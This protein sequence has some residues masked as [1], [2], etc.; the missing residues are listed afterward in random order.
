MRLTNFPMLLTLG[1]YLSP[2]PGVL[3]GLLVMLLTAQAPALIMV[4]RGNDPVSDHNWPAGS[5][6][7]ANLKS[8]VGWWEGPPF[9]GGQWCFLYRGD[10]K[11]A[12]AA[13]DLFAKIRA[14]RLDVFVHGDGPVENGFL[15][16]EKDPK[17]DTHV[18]WSFTVWNPESWNHLHN[19]ANSRF[20][21]EDPN[22]GYHQGVEP[23]RIDLYVGGKGID[24]ASIKMPAGVT[25]TDERA[26][27]AGIDGGS[28]IIADFYDMSTSKPIDGAQIRLENSGPKKEGAAAVTGK[29]DAKGHLLLKGVPAGSYQVL[30]SAEGYVARV[31]GYAEFRG[32]TLKR[33][34]VELAAPG[35]IEGTVTDTRGKRI[36]GVNVR[37]DAVVASNGRGYLLPES[38]LAVTDD[39][40]HFVISGLPHGSV[41]LFT[42]G[43]SYAPLDVLAVHAVPGRDVALHMTAT[44][45]LKGK[46]YTKAAEPFK[47]SVMA[48]P[49][50]DPIGKWG[51]GM[52][53]KPDGSY[54]FENV[55][56][57]DYVLTTDGRPMPGILVTVKAGET[58]EKDLV[59]RE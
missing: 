56:P 19:G 44:G 3:A 10:A 38:K 41:Q 37:A 57:G 24:L 31:L 20:S 52:N 21:A 45:T 5:L 49:P 58:T 40:G 53:V 25:V 8:R 59:G 47:G 36:A 46:V 2:P 42:Y 43:K 23:P 12:Q 54:L 51:G 29:A 7:L 15:K 28:A 30:A 33:F 17:S 50:K 34:T 16:D 48:N 18:D 13:L 4:G 26:S 9:G 55:P 6:D 27:A 1:R 14:P 11:A 32:D 22:G 35:E 39:N